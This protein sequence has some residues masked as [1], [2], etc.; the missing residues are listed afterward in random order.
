MRQVFTEI[1][2]WTEIDEEGRVVRTELEELRLRWTFRY[3]LH[4]LLEV[5]GFRLLREYS[6]FKGSEPAYGREL[7]VVAERN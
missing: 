7:V 2:R 6:D 4:H 1:W 3:E 5:C